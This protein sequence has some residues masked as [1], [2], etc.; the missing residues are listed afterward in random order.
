MLIGYTNDEAHEHL[1]G[2]VAMTPEQNGVRTRPNWEY[3]RARATSSRDYE[4]S[5]LVRETAH[6]QNGL[7]GPI[8]AT[9]QRFLHLFDGKST[10]AVTLAQCVIPRLRGRL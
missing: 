3:H 9:H 7:L 5:C 1:E 10:I 6:R 2:A 4:S 8:T